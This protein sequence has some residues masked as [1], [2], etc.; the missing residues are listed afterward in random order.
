MSPKDPI[1]AY[2]SRH[3]EPEAAAADR[4]EGTFG[5]AV[6][7]PAYGEGQ[8][9]FDTLGSVPRTAGGET[10]VVVVLNAR[11]DSPAK[12]HEANRAAS[13]RLVES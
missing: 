4:L 5:N 1:A 9:L 7:V 10:L 12:V 8:S 3:A 11:A 2:L 13:G 6:V